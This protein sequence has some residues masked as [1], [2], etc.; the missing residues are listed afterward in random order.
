[1]IKK[2]SRAPAVS[3]R[4]RSAFQQISAILTP[5]GTLFKQ[6][7]RNDRYVEEENLDEF[8]ELATKLSKKHKLTVA[9]VIAARRV[10]EMKRTNDLYVAN[11]DAFDEQIGG[12]G[13]LLESMCSAIEELKKDGE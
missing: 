1:L 2:K 3:R 4:E 7:P 9:D 6:A 8:L 13:E 10:L 12:I 5:M 11:G